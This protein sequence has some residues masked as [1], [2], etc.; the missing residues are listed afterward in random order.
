[1]TVIW[2]NTMLHVYSNPAPLLTLIINEKEGKWFLVFCILT[3][4]VS[5]SQRVKSCARHDC[6]YIVHVSCN[7]VR[8]Y[9]KWRLTWPWCVSWGRK[10]EENEKKKKLKRYHSVCLTWK[11]NGIKSRKTKEAKLFLCVKDQ[12]TN[13][14][15]VWS[16]SISQ[17]YLCIYF[18]SKI[19]LI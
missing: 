17:Y 5:T 18:A 12:G 3:Y 13:I 19:D 11:I 7:E 4:K 10:K 15:M 16:L 8:L 2:K 14:L 6:D 9:R 1:M